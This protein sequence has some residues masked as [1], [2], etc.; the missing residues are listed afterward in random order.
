MIESGEIE[1]EF[2]EFAVVDLFGNL[3]LFFAMEEDGA[4]QGVAAGELLESEIDF[5]LVGN[6]VELLGEQ[7]IH[8][9]VFFR[10]LDRPEAAEPVGGGAEAVAIVVEQ[11]VFGGEAVLGFVELGCPARGHEKCFEERNLAVFV[12]VGFRIGNGFGEVLAEAGEVLFVAAAGG[13]DDNAIGAGEFGEEWRASGGGVDYRE[14]T[15]KRM[16]PLGEIGSGEIGAA[17]I[18]AGFFAVEGAVADQDEP[19]G[20]GGGLGFGRE[21]LLQA[22]KIIT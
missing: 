9:G 19:E 20:A 18:E 5:G 13:G 11:G 16:K 17:K 1:E 15:V 12:Q 6:E 7:A 10:L 22:R 2:F 21:G 3:L 14:R 8:D 4:L